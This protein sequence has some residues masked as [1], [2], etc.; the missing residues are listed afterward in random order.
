M[1]PLT[2][3]QHCSSAEERGSV[4]D[5]NLVFRADNIII[6][7]FTRHHYITSSLGKHFICPKSSDILK[8]EFKKTTKCLIRNLKL[9]AH[10]AL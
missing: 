1:A 4:T 9:V 2:T 10:R 5:I 6:P 7:P 3:N 8:L